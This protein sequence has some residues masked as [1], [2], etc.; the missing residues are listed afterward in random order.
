MA[1]NILVIVLCVIAVGAGVFA[2]WLEHGDASHEKAGK[3]GR[4]NEEN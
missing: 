1:Q 3:E 4:E 2:L